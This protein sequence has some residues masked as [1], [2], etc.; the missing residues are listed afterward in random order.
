MILSRI[1]S[2]KPDGQ[3]THPTH[4][5]MFQFLVGFE[6]GTFGQANAKTSQPRYKV[7]D[8]AAYEIT[9]QT[10]KGGNKLKVSIGEQDLANATRRAS[11]APEPARPAPHTE[12]PPQRSPEPARA[13][14]MTINGQTVGMAMKEAIPLVSLRHEIS[15]EYGEFWEKVHHYA[16]QIIHQASRL[17]KGDLSRALDP[18]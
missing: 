10:P 13:S 2:L 14:G 1:D 8:K 7:G 15:P 9:G 5:M 17:E 16:S 18:F 12:N 11:A 3:W 4:G 6:D